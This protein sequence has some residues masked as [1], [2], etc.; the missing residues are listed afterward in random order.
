MWSSPTG[1][2]IVNGDKLKTLFG[3]TDPV[4][5]GKVYG[6]IADGSARKLYQPAGTH[7]N[8]HIS[9]EAIGYA[10]E[11]MQTTLKGGNNLPPSDQIW[12]WKEIGTFMALIGMILFLFPFGALLVQ[13]SLFQDL[14]SPVPVLKGISGR[15]WL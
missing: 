4:V 12:Y 9:V 5:V 11:W 1:K 13:T 3:T 10:M 2:S 7:P 8:D 14:V 15:G 6:S